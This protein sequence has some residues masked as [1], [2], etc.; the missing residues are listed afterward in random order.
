MPEALEWFQCKK[1][2][3]RQ[4]WVAELAGKTFKCSCGSP[5]TC[6]KGVDMSE[7]AQARNTDGSFSDT[8]FEETG[9]STHSP[10]ETLDPEI[11]SIEAEAAAPPTL[12]EVRA[13]KSFYVWTAGMLFG[14]AMLIHA[15]ITQ[16]T[17]YIVLASIAVP[18]TF[19]KF[20][21]AK[22]RWQKGRSFSTALTRSLGADR[23]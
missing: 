1:C 9:E 17:A 8:M 12:E 5:V 13:T 16:W 10:Y 22:R 4:R 3:R 19:W 11:F 23:S 18:I 7:P 14:L 6:P 15:F 20:Y 2:G 21:R